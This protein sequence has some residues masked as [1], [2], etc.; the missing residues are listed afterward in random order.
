MI[1]I[2]KGLFPLFLLSL[3]NGCSQNEQ[4]YEEKPVEE[5]Y[6]KALDIIQGEN[7]ITAA[8]AFEE[9]ERQHPYSYWA[10][11]A[12]LMA[13]Y[14]YYKGRAYE[15][16]IDALDSFIQLHPGHEDTAYAY[17]LKGFCYYHQLSIVERDQKM[18]ELALEALNELIRRFPHSP[19]AK[20]GRLKIQLTKDHLAGKDMQV[21]RFYQKANQPLAALGR[22]N[23]VIENYQGTT[24]IPE[25]LHRIVECYLTVGLYEQARRSAVVL[26]YNYPG[27]DWYKDSYDLLKKLESSETKTSSVQ[28]IT[29]GLLA[30]EKKEVPSET[31]P[32]DETRE[33]STEEK[34][35]QKKQGNII[36]QEG[37]TD[38]DPPPA[39]EMKE[40]SSTKEKIDSPNQDDE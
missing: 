14:A 23:N 17:Y 20:D 29:R 38:L 12:Q 28:D 18:T 5:L 31:L 37:L 1:K 33:F 4:K 8:Q 11:K 22:F 27:S 10:T 6:N 19:Y 30:P 25:A 34:H 3:L 39:F 16:A 35:Q 15:R 40:S 26:G 32:S 21:G 13:A 2:L 36:L 9:V 24:H 7:Y